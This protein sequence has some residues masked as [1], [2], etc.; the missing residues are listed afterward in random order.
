MTG[1]DFTP[2]EEDQLFNELNQ[3]DQRAQTYRATA[4]PAVAQTA[5][6]IFRTHPYAAPGTVLSTAKAVASGAMSRE[7]ADR[8]IAEA[9]ANA[10]KWAAMEK[11]KQKKKSWWER[12][13]WDKAKTASRWTM[14]GL[15]FTPQF[16]QGGIAQIF[17]ENDSVAGWFISTDLGTLIA[18]DEVAGEGWFMGG[19]AAELQAERARR[20]RGE[21]DGHAF[22]IGRGIATTFLQP[23][24]KEYN[25]LSGLV[26]AGAAIAVPSLPGA[27]A[28]KGAVKGASEVTGLRL[29]AGIAEAE[30][31]AIDVSKVSSWLRS[32]SGSAVVKRIGKIENVDEAMRIFPRVNEPSFWTGVVEKKTDK[33]V[34]DFL[35][36]TLGT[37]GPRNIADINLSRLDDIKAGLVGRSNLVSK[38]MASVPGQHLVLEGGNARDSAQSVRNMNNYLKLLK[39]DDAKRVGLI[40]DYTKALVEANGDVYQVVGEFQKVMNAS[41]E[42]MGVPDEV[43]ST[44]VKKMRDFTQDKATYGAADDVGDPTSF[45]A[46]VTVRGKTEKVL[47][48]GPSNIQVVPDDKTTIRNFISG[49]DAGKEIRTGQPTTVTVYRGSDGPARRGQGESSIFGPAFYGTPSYDDAAYYAGRDE[50]AWD[51]YGKPTTYS[52]MQGKVEKY[53]ITLKNPLVVTDNLDQRVLNPGDMTWQELRIKAG[54][55]YNKITP[56]DTDAPAKLRAAVEE[57]GH[58]GIII[59]LS[60]KYGNTTRGTAISDVMGG[61][62]VI[63]FP[64][65][66]ASQIVERPM[67]VDAPLATA[68]LESEH[69]RALSVTLPDPR[70]V[71][72]MMSK[73][74]WIVG[75]GKRV[76]DPEK[77]RQLRMPLSALESFQQEIWRPI[78]L[79]TGGYVLRNLTDSALRTSTMPTL[80]GGVFHP[81]QWI[82]IAS[83]KKFR[84]DILGQAFDPDAAE[85]LLRGAQDEFAE[86]VGQGMREGIDPV[87]RTRREVAT[88]NWAYA[89]R[90]RDKMYRKGIQD[91]V[92]L[93][94]DDFVTRSL[95]QKASVD[96]VV[97]ELM[98]TAFGRKYLRNLQG[99]W[100]NRTLTNA[101]GQKTV[102]TVEI[103]KADGTINEQNVRSFVED[104]AKA[105]LKSV[106]RD[107][108]LLMKAV[109]DGTFIRADGVEVSIF[110]TTRGGSRTGYKHSVDED[111]ILNSWDNEVDKLINSGADLKNEYK[112]RIEGKQLMGE[113]ERSPQTRRMLAG[114]NK[115]TDYFFSSLYP[116]RSAYLMQSPAFRQFYYKQV[117]NLI[118]DL[119]QTGVKNLE[120]SL[121]KAAKAENK[122]LDEAW[123]QGYLGDKKLAENIYNKLKGITPSGG[124][125]LEL[126]QLDAYAKGFALDETKRLFYNAT[127][128]SN[129]AD[130][131]RIVAPFGSAWAE[132]MGSWTK[133]ALTNPEA[134]RKVSVTVQGL[135]NADPDGDGR[136]FFWKDPVTGEYV[137][138]YPFS[139]KLGPLVSG[140]GGIGAVGG[141]ALG[142]LPGL[143]AGAA[144]GAAVG[145]G[146]QAAGLATPGATLY[147]PAKTLSMGFN[148]L[149]GV[150][151]FAQ[152]AASKILGNLPEADAVMKFIAPYGEPELTVIPSWAQ[153]LQA[154]IQD[155]ESNRLLG[156]LTVDTMRVLQQ[157]GEYDLS[158]PADRE[159][160]EKDATGRARVML[161]MRS[162][163][164]FVGPTRPDVDFK[165]ETYKGDMFTR[166]ISKA[167][168]VMQDEDYDTAV[169]RF[170]NTF[171]DDA[172]LY[173]AGKSKAVAGGLDASTK[174]GQFERDNKSLFARYGDVAGFFAPTGENFDYQVYLRQLQ[175]GARRRLKPSEMIE[176]AQSQV[177]RA[178]YR[179]LTRQAGANPNSDQREVLR[180]A[181]AKIVELFPG[182][183]TTPVDINKLP[184]QIQ[185][186]QAA[187]F[188]SITDGNPVAE[189]ARLYLQ[190][191]EAALQQAFAR[192]FTSLGGKK[193]ADLRGMLRA[194]A[195]EIIKRYPE[196]E[197]LYDRVLFNEIDVDAGE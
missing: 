182:F 92:T 104:Y 81:I 119:T 45:G 43:R 60:D 78:T 68:A 158:N 50:I 188:D 111:G 66:G 67:V 195:D 144:G 102:G 7:M 152:V 161:M 165:V 186:V 11:P 162:L 61:D 194:A 47:E 163:G 80:K 185:Q 167:F 155:P 122:V 59:R 189:G 105:R 97:D 151:P 2:E 106:T 174:F 17:D 134:I 98:N 89:R 71:R 21:I 4:N 172:F 5:G 10:A 113:A 193:V 24:S 1:W 139:D 84:G 175:T 53:E 49:D 58:D 125:K 146:L 197:R 137:F 101:S 73:V 77:Y 35:E 138:N 15:N 196:F 14:A 120:T 28:I 170:L 88:K 90:G 132:V 136:G 38:W 140:L 25:I 108:E 86:A 147:A 177:G 27:G 160:L 9:S 171:G 109:A 48:E 72:R 79:M 57:M 142:G 83:Y 116:R 190:I 168:R 39:V 176:E 31:A 29:L 42:Q 103:F 62:Q 115:S 18:N 22:T 127:E 94:H 107:H 65:K 126:D 153:K 110:E 154:A 95:A 131:L 55:P 46:K 19:R 12:N 6:Q 179:S 178:L 69:L 64:R 114:W 191:R 52:E 192:G 96:E 169:E 51:R 184:G 32:A 150:G 70:Q 183:G 3:L 99:R 16:V 173:I 133:I 41:L 26:D 63:A 20:Y 112:Y 149:P 33:E 85:A 130:I 124:G 23:G 129:F 37:T 180:A 76:S 36:E 164:Q 148:F 121:S 135:R 13:V 187:A 181:R 157:T 128:K 75:K 34:I 123:L 56:R 118:D 87:S 44:L 156:D 117:D 100:T 166:E 54:L 74:G 30:S 143:A 141:L 93:L 145:A 8:I 82:Q 91:E 159:R 40:D